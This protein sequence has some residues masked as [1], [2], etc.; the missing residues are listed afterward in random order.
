MAESQVAL[1]AGSV[2]ACLDPAELE[3]SATHQ[4]KG[5]S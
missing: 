3:R 5:G 2:S 1:Q 4:V